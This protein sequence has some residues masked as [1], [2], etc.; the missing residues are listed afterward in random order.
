MAKTVVNVT[1]SLPS[2]LHQRVKEAN[3]NVS[4]VARKALQQ[5]LQDRQS[6]ADLLPLETRIEQLEHQVSTLTTWMDRV[7]TGK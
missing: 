4:R 7:R 5:A 6:V 2:D 1:I 3:L